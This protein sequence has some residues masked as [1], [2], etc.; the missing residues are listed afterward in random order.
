MYAVTNSQ[1]NHISQILVIVF[2]N[3]NNEIRSNEIRIKQELPVQRYN[4]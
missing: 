2:K 4:L 1:R 3:R